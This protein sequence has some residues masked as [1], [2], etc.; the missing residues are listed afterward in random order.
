[1]YKTKCN[2]CN[3]SE[4]EIKFYIIADDLENPQPY[5]IDCFKKFEQEMLLTIFFTK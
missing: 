3:K 1:M 2:Y 4:G 5:H